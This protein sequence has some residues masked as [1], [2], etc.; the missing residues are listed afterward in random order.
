VSADEAVRLRRMLASAERA[1]AKAATAR[2]ALPPGSSRARVTS[3][4]AKWMRAA[5]YRDML[6]R[7]LAEVEASHEA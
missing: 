3:A 5:E 6:L 1:S 7:Q 4:N 2:S